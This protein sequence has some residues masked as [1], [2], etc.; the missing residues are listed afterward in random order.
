MPGLNL[1]FT[2]LMTSLGPLLA[3]SLED[4]KKRIGKCEKC[5]KNLFCPFPIYKSVKGFYGDKDC[6][7]VAAQPS[8]SVFPTRWDERLYHCMAEYGFDN[9]HLTDLVKCRGEPE[10]DLS[11]T[12]VDRCIGWLEAEVKIVNPQVI[13]A[14]GKKAFDELK[15]RFEP[16]LMVTHYSNRFVNDLEYEEEF[17]MLREYL[18]SGNYQHGTKIKNLLKPAR[19]KEKKRQREFRE[20]VDSLKEQGVTGEEYREA[21]MKWNKGDPW[22]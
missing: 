4:L 20:F 13:V 22:T 11:R 10:K 2:T 3:M 1:A 12:E 7:F 8:M 14:L 19:S 18:D 5:G 16:V 15:D 9:A 21:I 17:K 6:V